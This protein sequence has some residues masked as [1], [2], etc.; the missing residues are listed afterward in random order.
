MPFETRSRT[1]AATE[2]WLVS[3]LGLSAR[4]APSRLVS[5]HA[6]SR[7][8]QFSYNFLTSTEGRRG[9]VITAIM[10]RFKIRNSRSLSSSA[11]RCRLSSLGLP[12]SALVSRPSDVGSLNGERRAATF[13]QNFSRKKIFSKFSQRHSFREI[14]GEPPLSARGK[15]LRPS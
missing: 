14:R 8:S 4:G 3:R 10:A 6:P 15:L 1:L 12:M 11:F 9:L 7:L 13:L 5:S 2:T